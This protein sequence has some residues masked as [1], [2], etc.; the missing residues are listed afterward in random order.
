MLWH[1]AS[2]ATALAVIVPASCTSARVRPAVDSARPALAVRNPVVAFCN[3]WSPANI[4][5]DRSGRVLVDVYFASSDTAPTAKQIAFV[6][7]LPATIV[8]RFPFAAVRAEV[9]RAAFS[10]LS[11]VADHVRLPLYRQRFDTQVLILYRNAPTNDDKSL[12]ERLGGRVEEVLEPTHTIS[13]DLPDTA[14]Q[15]LR[16]YPPVAAVDPSR[17]LCLR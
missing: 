15:I 17:I 3:D 14:V 10:N 1:L 12:I 6:E 8:H 5:A 13:A 4:A 7:A 2:G 9:P 11:L 16:R